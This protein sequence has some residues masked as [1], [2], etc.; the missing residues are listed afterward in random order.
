[1]GVGGLD[2]EFG[3]LFRRAFAS[4]LFPNHVIQ[5]LGVRH[6]KGILLHGPPGTGK[7]L[8]ARQIGKLL[9]GREPKI[10]NG[11]ELLS[12]F[13]GNTEANV[14]L[15]F[16]EAEEE[17]K[18]VGDKSMLHIIILDEIDSLCKVRGSN[19][20]GGGAAG[21][22]ND[23]VVNQIL[24][25]IDGVYSLN[26]ILVIGMTNRKE[27]IDPALLRPGRLEVHI[28]IGLPDEQGREQILNIHT[29]QMRLNHKLAE[30]VDL[31]YLSSVTKNFSGAEL[32]GLVKS[33]TSFALSKNIEVVKTDVKVDP[34]LIVVDKTHF[35][36]ALAEVKPAFGASEDE[37]KSI[38][39]FQDRQLLHYSEEFVKLLQLGRTWIHNL[40][41]SS[42][43]SL[44]TILLHG[45]NGCGK[46]LISR[47]VGHRDQISICQ[48]NTS[49]NV[50]R[51]FF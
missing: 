35:E 48:G 45:Q 51:I 47:S 38:L 40:E 11:P 27:L 49:R 25:M 2:K 6:V 44:L 31:K 22:V 46:N 32:E 30:T 10:V 29:A 17:Q 5:Q 23:T 15:L 42:S 41:T 12:K 1:M 18:K 21:S 28:E 37:L 34:D 7:T 14:R 19:G 9:K 36:H 26:N 8:I 20:G 13:V 39:N 3:M 4:R 16:K 50:C 43:T 33:A 24:A